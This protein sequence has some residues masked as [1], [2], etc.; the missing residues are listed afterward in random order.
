MPKWVGQII[1]E[2]AVITGTYRRVDWSPAATQSAAGVGGHLV[3]RL[4]AGGGA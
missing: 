3:G 2:A 4:E 1:S